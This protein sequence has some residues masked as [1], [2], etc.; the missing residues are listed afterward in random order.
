MAKRRKV[1]I[2]DVIVCE[3]IELKKETSFMV[4]EK[5]RTAA[6]RARRRKERGRRRLRKV[7]AIILRPSLTAAPLRRCFSR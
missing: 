5:R 3:K 2:N 1:G 7:V 6:R 4:D